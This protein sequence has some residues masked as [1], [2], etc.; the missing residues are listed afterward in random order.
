MQNIANQIPD[1]FTNSRKIIESYIPTENA[2][3]RVE[4]LEGQHDKTNE[5]KVRLKRGRLIGS[6][7]NSLEEENTGK[8][9]K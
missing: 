4:I 3:A 2:P 8:V 6:K 9:M 1:E 7:D 5:S